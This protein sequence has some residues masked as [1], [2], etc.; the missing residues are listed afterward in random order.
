MI[1]RRK[2]NA[3]KQYSK[4]KRKEAN[5]SSRFKPFKFIA[6]SSVFSTVF[7]GL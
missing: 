6:S 3:N 2:Y 1:D 5:A 4:R 7:F